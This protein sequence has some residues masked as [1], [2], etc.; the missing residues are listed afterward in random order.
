M[1]SSDPQLPIEPPPVVSRPPAPSQAPPQVAVAQGVVGALSAA[2]RTIPGLLGWLAVLLLGMIAILLA[3]RELRPVLAAR[4]AE[5]EQVRQSAWIDQL[6]SGP[7]REDRRKAVQAILARGPNA[8][9]A[10]LDVLTIVKENGLATYRPADEALAE[11][12]P[13]IMPL[14]LAEIASPR[15]QRRAAVCCVLREMGP[16]A[17]PALSGV[18]ERLADESLWIRGLAC[19]ILGNI[20]GKAAPAVTALAKAAQSED[21]FIRRRAIATLGRIGPPAKAAAPALSEIL[22]TEKRYDIAFAAD[23]ALHQIDL[24]SMVE[25]GLGRASPAIRALVKQIDSN[26]PF[27]AVAAL[28]TLG[29]AGADG[30]PAVAAIALALRHKNKWIRDAAATALGKLGSEARV[31]RSLLQQA[32][33]DPEPEVREAARKALPLLGAE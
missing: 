5:Q 29:A 10:A 33:D 6:K 25:R 21:A 27:E 26:D 16:A 3:V 1:S 15:V 17:E 28:K 20:G 12:G 9:L 8:A 13:Q 4:R 18:I 7:S 11:A 32:L 19:D 23:S 14:L 24:P 31:V 30:Q 22:R 2:I